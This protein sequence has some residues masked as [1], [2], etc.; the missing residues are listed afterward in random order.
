MPNMTKKQTKRGK[1]SF[2][3]T[4]RLAIRSSAES[5]Y[6][7]SKATGIDA[8]LLSRFLLGKSGLSVAN[9]DRLVE[10]LGLVV[11]LPAR[12]TGQAAAAVGKR[13]STKAGG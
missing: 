8:S 7:I 12:R 9:L 13:S 1:S 11:K 4:L 5:Q 3:D 6:A 2:S 10:H